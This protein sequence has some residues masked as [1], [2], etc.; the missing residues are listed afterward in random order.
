[1][2]NPK[3][4]V[5]PEPTPA[6]FVARWQRWLTRAYNEVVVLRDYEASCDDLV[7]VV[8]A[9]RAIPQPNYVMDYI[10]E[11]Y[12][13]AVAVGIRRQSDADRQGR[14]ANLRHVMTVGC[15]PMSEIT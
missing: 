15:L 14:V 12:G 9:N 4:A 3:S 8:E 5:A 2:T 1:M 10:R 13:I 7:K 11:L 6:E